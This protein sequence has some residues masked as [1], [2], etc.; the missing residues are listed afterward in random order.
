MKH[1]FNQK[2]GKYYSCKI[3]NVNI[4]LNKNEEQVWNEF[5]GFTYSQRIEYLINYY[6]KHNKEK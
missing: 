6:I 3:R 1:S 5:N 2:T 4:Y